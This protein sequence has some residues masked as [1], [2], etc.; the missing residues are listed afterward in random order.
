MDDCTSFSRQ[1]RI[2]HALL[3]NASFIDN[4]GLLHGKMGIAIYFFCL[5]RET[6]NKIYE[7]YA[8][9]LIDEICD[10]IN[11]GTSCDFEN[12]L[13]GIGWGIE[14]LVKEGFIEADPDEILEELDNR[15]IHELT[16]HTP[17]EIGLLRGLTGYI[18]YFHSR[19]KEWE[20]ETNRV[21]SNREALLN[22]IV[23]LEQRIDKAYSSSTQEELWPEPD[24][25]DIAW[26]LPL[27]LWV[28]AGLLDDGIYREKVRL[29]ISIILDSLQSKTVFPRLQSNR[30]LLA[31]PIEKLKHC[32]FEQLSFDLF[33]E[34]TIN[35]QAGLNREAIL[36]ELR[37][38]P[39]SLQHGMFGI[40]MIYWQLFLLTGNEQLQ[41]ESHYWNTL[42]FK[43]PETKQGYAGFYVVTG[44]EDKAFGL[45]N[46]VAGINLLQL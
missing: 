23:L 20:E 6:G 14:Y 42:V 13:A 45:L 19:T 21:I 24:Q 36:S 8:G 30:L 12:G 38:K 27:I 31:L 22:A 11:S 40:S 15:I 28:L 5:A 32:K 18:A 41:Q 44:S 4:L 10:E 3:L 2:A 33:N 34:L 17:E 25:F 1:Q 7:D 37:A 16:Y 46:G 43:S 9:E 26:D 29:I 35:L 39:V